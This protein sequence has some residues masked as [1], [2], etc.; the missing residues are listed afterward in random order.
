MSNNDS[1]N[2]ENL[3]TSIR[4]HSVRLGLFALGAAVL[5][6]SVN[7]LTTERIAAQRLTAER[8]ALAA[9]LPPVLHDNDLLEHAF[10]LSPATSDFTQIALLGLSSARQGYLSRLNGNSNGVI[11]PVETAEGYSG[12]IL[13]LLG[14]DQEGSITGVRV[15]Q[16][17]ETPGLGDK[18]ELRKDDWILDFDTLS[19]QNPAASG[20][21]VKK[22]GGVFDQ[23]VGATI[24]PRAVVLAVHRALQFFELNRQQLLS[25]AAQERSE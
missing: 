20:W 6:A 13:L 11:L 12:T 10:T 17:S 9:V 3:G 5:L 23:F 4:R 18:L 2:S 1:G 16:H 24:T 7:L 19:L 21:Q 15:L 14:I 22:D 8:E 25:T